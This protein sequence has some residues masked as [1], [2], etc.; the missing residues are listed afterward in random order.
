MVV[1]YF[2]QHISLKITFSISFKVVN[3]PNRSFPCHLY[4]NLFF[5]LQLF[6][7]KN[8]SFGKI[9]PTFENIYHTNLK[10]SEHEQVLLLHKN[11]RFIT[12]PNINTLRNFVLQKIKTR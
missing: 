10:L 11:K 6:S 5:F 8:C 12:L 7:Q 2:S 1:I 4:S 3:R 9:S